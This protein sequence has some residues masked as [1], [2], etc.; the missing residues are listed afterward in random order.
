MF[1]YSVI[2]RNNLRDIVRFTLI[3]GTELGKY[4]TIENKHQLQKEMFTHILHSNC[5]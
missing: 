1:Q 3:N 4:V 5:S 2:S